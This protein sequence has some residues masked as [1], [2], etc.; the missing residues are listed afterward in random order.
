MIRPTLS[1]ALFDELKEAWQSIDIFFKFA[2]KKCHEY[3]I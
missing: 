2:E 3:S 1:A